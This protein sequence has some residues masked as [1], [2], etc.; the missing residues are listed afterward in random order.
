MKRRLI[1][2]VDRSGSM[3]TIQK[4]TE[5][6]ISAFLKSV[7]PG[8]DEVTVS[9]YQFDTTW[10][11]VYKDTPLHAIP[12]Y[13]LMPRGGTALL[14]AIGLTVADSDGDE[15]TTLVI[16]TDGE[17]NSSKEYGLREV[18]LL[19]EHK[20]AQGWKVIYIGANQ[21]AFQVAESLG[22]TRG[23]TL[24][25]VATT[26]GT[27]SSWRSVSGLYD[28]SSKGGDLEFTEE[29]REASQ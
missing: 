2:V 28:R 6:G 10:E 7:E 26:A 12:A 1:I 20:Q 8:E 23:A 16:A 9:L 14:D 24:N 3:V 4:D 27:E 11:N 18:K 29:E 13:R 15:D 19:L 17:E 5:G 25:Y 22:V 21:D